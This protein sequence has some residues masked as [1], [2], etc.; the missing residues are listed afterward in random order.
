LS[1]IYNKS[2]YINDYHMKNIK[3]LIFVV[4]I[5]LLF[6]CKQKASTEETV[7]SIQVEQEEIV[8]QEEEDTTVIETEQSDFQFDE[9]GY[10]NISLTA[11][12][13]DPDKKNPTNIREKPGG[14]VLVPLEPG[15][16]YMVEIIGQNNGWFRINM[17]H[18]FDVNN[19]IDIPGQYGWMHSS[20]LAVRT[21][22]YG[23]QKLNVYA[24][25]DKTAEVVGVIKEEIE[26]R[27]TK[28]YK[29]FV[30]IRFTDS[31]GKQVEGWIEKKWLCGNPVTNC[32]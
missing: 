28:I 11:Y 5:F 8:I 24:A 21:S 7:E 26:V 13:Q 10:A 17:I 29:E 16:D 30:L 32:C 18:V 15:G 27:F 20:V 12:V 4:C 9:K 2:I 22:N 23:G 6:S 3:L 14:E 1:D 25:P 31:K 19:A